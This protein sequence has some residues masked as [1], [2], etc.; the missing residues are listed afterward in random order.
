MTSQQTHLTVEEVE[1]QKD[2]VPPPRKQAH[3]TDTEIALVRVKYA[4]TVVPRQSVT[5]L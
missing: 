1:V 5:P 3:Y 4:A 2:G